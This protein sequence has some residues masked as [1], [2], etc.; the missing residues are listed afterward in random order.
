VVCY[1]VNYKVRNFEGIHWI[2]SRMGLQ[3]FRPTK[4]HRIKVHWELNWASRERERQEATVPTR[5][6]TAEMQVVLPG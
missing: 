1:N 5:M 3:M 4:R 2:D 6:R